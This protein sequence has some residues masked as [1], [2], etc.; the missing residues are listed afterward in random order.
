MRALTGVQNHDIEEDLPYGD[1]ED[2]RDRREREATDATTDIRSFK[3]IHLL[4]GSAGGSS[5]ETKHSERHIRASTSTNEREVIKEFWL[6]LPERDRRA[7]IRVEKDAVLKKLKEQQKHTCSCTVCKRKRTAIE[8]ELEGLYDAYFDEL[9]RYAQ[10]GDPKDDAKPNESRGTPVEVGL[11][12]DGKEDNAWEA[13]LQTSS[14]EPFTDGLAFT[15]GLL[16]VADD[17]LRNDGKRFI[18]M[19]EQLAERRM[20]SEKAAKKEPPDYFFDNAK[21]A[22]EKSDIDREEDDEGDDQ[23]DEGED[24]DDDEEDDEDDDDDDV[25]SLPTYYN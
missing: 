16:T 24:D 12:A 10:N 8:E 4:H 1:N 5:V 25:V 23:V 20:A 18:E 19:M 15:G 2:N 22:V 3:R 13:T 11:V 7:L 17:L 6:G 21:S 9:K 14:V